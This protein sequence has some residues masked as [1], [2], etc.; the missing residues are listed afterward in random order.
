[1]WVSISARSCEV[2]MALGDAHTKQGTTLPWKVHWGPPF[3]MASEFCRIIVASPGFDYVSLVV[4]LM[5]S[6]QLTGRSLASFFDSITTA[7]RIGSPFPVWK[8]G[9]VK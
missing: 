6:F 2:I 1:M 8:E 9:T 4:I 5:P 3:V 7:Q